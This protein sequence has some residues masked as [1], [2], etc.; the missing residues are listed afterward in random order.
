M[1][2]I[3][4]RNTASYLLPRLMTAAEPYPRLHMAEGDFSRACLTSETD[5]ITEFTMYE[6]LMTI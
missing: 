5:R 1:S 3:L 4:A 6:S 2:A